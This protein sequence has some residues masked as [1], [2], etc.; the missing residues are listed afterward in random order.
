[1]DKDKM[2]QTLNKMIELIQPH[3]EEER[4]SMALALYVELAMKDENT[5]EQILNPALSALFE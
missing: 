3:T 5:T 2:H 1:M 4:L